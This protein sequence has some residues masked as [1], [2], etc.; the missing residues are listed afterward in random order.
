M[1]GA[2][3]RSALNLDVL[4]SEEN[5][6]QI[7]EILEKATFNEIMQSKCMNEFEYVPEGDFFSFTILLGE[8]AMNASVVSKNGEDYIKFSETLSFNSGN[9]WIGFF[10]ESWYIHNELQLRNIFI[11]GRQ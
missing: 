10:W 1:F 3:Q 7:D 8:C 4:I 11:N 9:K 5:A 2:V 6:A